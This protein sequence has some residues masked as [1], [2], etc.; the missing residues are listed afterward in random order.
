MR[1]L[2]LGAKISLGF[3]LALALLVTISVIAFR[4]AN[5]L[6]ETNREVV[7][8]HEV[9]AALDQVLSELRDSETGQRG[10][11]ITGEEPYLEPYQDSVGKVE[12]SAQ[13][14]QQLTVDNPNWQRQIAA[15][16]PLITQKLAELQETIELRQKMGFEAAQRVVLTDRGKQLMDDIR[17]VSAKIESTERTLLIQR[18]AAAEAATQNT[19]LAIVYGNI[20][21]FV[22]VGLS[23]TVVS[24]DLTKRRQAEQAL[25]AL[26]A[27]LEHRVEDRTAELVRT[28]TAL[29]QEIAER[30]RAEVVIREQGER[31]RVTLASI[32]DAVI[33]TDPSGRVTFLNSVAQTLTGWKS[34][35]ALQHPL[36]EVF[37][38]M[39]EITRQPVESPVTKVLREGGVAGLANHTVLRA[40]DG[41]ERPIDDS[42]ALIRD[43]QGQILG[44]VLVFRDITERRRAEE[45][46]SFLAEASAALATSLEYETTLAQVAQLAIPRLAEWCSVYVVEGEGEIR[47][48]AVAH[49][50]PAKATWAK[51]LQR[52]YPLEPD[53][54]YGVPN[55]FRT[56]R[57]ERYTNITDA[58]LVGAARGNAEI[59][60]VLRKIAPSSIMIVPMRARGRTVGVMT[61]TATQARR[62]YGEAELVLAESLAQ[63]AALAIDN[64]HLY[65]AV[66]EALQ[67]KSES[68]ALLDALFAA[69]P[70]GLAFLDPTFRFVRINEA[71]AA[72]TGIPREAHVGQRVQELLPDLWPVVEP[73]FCSVLETG[74][75]VINH[76]V[77]GETPAARGEQRYWLETCYPVRAQE[78]QLL[79]LGL[80]AIEITE[81]KQAEHALAQHAE[82]L[83]DSNE[84]LQRF[85]YVASHDLQEPLRMVTSYVQLL[86]KRYESSLDDEARQFISYA[87]E[88]T[89]RMKA[90]IDDLLAYAR[91]ESR[92]KNLELIE[93]ESVL[94]RVLNDIQVS[95]ADHDAVITHDPLPPVLADRTQLTLLF[96]NLLSNALKFRTTRPPHVHISARQEGLQWL[97]TVK[98]NGIGIEPQYAN[99]I[100]ELFQ[101]LHARQEY[102]G[103]G[104]GLAICKRIVERH[105][106]RI[107]VES[108]LGKGATFFF[109]LP[110]QDSMPSA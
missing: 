17:S 109:T 58:Q 77:C 47:L 74:Q 105:G 76:E 24:R 69:T 19:L 79:G 99:K 110:T 7:R 104:L 12:Q 35:E 63:R 57:S 89:K 41:S 85:A 106:G 23:G 95:I 40:K 18:T 80:A 75:P 55:V 51:E 81:R 60:Q 1:R 13:K 92:G 21:A 48:L 22:F 83:R 26:N 50:D 33:V 100:F 84:E 67:A 53:L 94:Q 45:A 56:G 43:D 46:Q 71:L 90:L 37:S 20:L 73:V 103:T 68:L 30:Q 101:R 87:V 32:G 8:T 107:W 15:L 16:Q 27:E 91:V 52:R 11:L 54:P 31:F 39:H 70:I 88:G 102:P 86:E 42:G 44:V 59:L 97:L 3:L 14:L 62:Q 98:D 78:E 25:A 65:R 2:V 10:Y 36:D 49:A 6:I 64:A 108:E 28:N 38:I 96:Q 29:Q 66:Q 4:N 34:E 9:L 82:A 93:S 5:A 72:M 61:F